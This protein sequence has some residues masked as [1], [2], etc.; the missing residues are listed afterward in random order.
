MNEHNLR[1]ASVKNK[2]YSIIYSE[3]HP[4]PISLATMNFL[5]LYYIIYTTTNNIAVILQF[6]DIFWILHR[7]KWMSCMYCIDYDTSLSKKCM[8]VKVC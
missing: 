6:I 2:F 1:P 5:L 7:I 4:I 3:V 8:H